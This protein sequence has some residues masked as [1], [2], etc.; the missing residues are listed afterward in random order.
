MSV[1]DTGGCYCGAVRY[2]SRKP[3]SQSG[4]CHCRMCQRWTGSPC[5]T[6]VFFETESFSFTKGEPKTFLTSP[7]LERQFCGDCGTSI[8]HRYIIGD[9][10]ETQIIFIGTL[11]E[12]H[13][14]D[15]P[16]WYFGAESHLP[17]W[18]ILKDDVPQIRADT[19]ENIKAA[20]AAAE[21][22]SDS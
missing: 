6:G 21:R 11:D 22:G 18:Y 10:A 9:L 13:R 1:P 8:G 5:A 3:S 14:Y 19:D 7:I 15:G 16:G 2:E 12:P 20:F 17:N 4:T